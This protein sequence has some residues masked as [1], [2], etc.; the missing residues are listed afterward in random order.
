M[1]TTPNK[2]NNETIKHCKHCKTEQTVVYTLDINYTTGDSIIKEICTKCNKTN[3]K[4][5]DKPSKNNITAEQ[6]MKD[7]NKRSLKEESIDIEEIIKMINTKNI[8]DPEYYNNR[9]K[10]ITKYIL[11]DIDGHETLLDD[12]AIEIID[13]RIIEAE[14]SIACLKYIKNYHKMNTKQ[15][16][17]YAIN[18]M[19]DSTTAYQIDYLH[20]SKKVLPARAI[21]E[22][23]TI[24]DFYIGRLN[25]CIMVIDNVRNNTG[26]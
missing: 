10:I 9:S 15:K 21:Q 17:K 4:I 11:T 19:L 8:E 6:I 7:I 14:I 1:K 3:N 26:W 12:E 23:K 5:I 25:T 16:S 2:K 13:N 22:L 20:N 18:T 24:T